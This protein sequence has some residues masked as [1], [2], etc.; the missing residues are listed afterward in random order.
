LYWLDLGNSA[1]TGQFVLGQPRNALNRNKK[2]RL[3]TVAEVYPEIIDSHEEDHLEPACSA[4]EAL[5]RQEPFINQNLAYEA[6]AMLT[7]L[8][9]HGSLSYRGGF[10]NLP[11]GR[12]VPLPIGKNGRFCTIAKCG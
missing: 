1:A 6:L 3:P 8:L 7:Q 5:T 12:V 10:C 2:C 4:A 11:T 9:R